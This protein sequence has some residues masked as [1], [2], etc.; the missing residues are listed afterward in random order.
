MIYGVDHLSN[1]DIRNIM[2]IDKEKAKIKRLNLSNVS[3]SF[4]SF[5]Y[6]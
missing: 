5:S 3:I 1:K 4:E 6:L 2:K